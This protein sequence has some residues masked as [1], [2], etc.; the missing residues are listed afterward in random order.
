M[1]L[2]NF[3]NKAKN[4]INKTTFNQKNTVSFLAYNLLKKFVVSGQA[5]ASCLD[6]AHPKNT[7]LKVLKNVSQRSMKTFYKLSDKYQKNQKGVLAQSNLI[8]SDKR[9]SLSPK[10]KKLLKLIENNKPRYER[11]DILLDKLKSR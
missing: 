3:Y 6:N 7:R 11:I 2:L 8:Q 10:A 4:K 9:S 1:G 5:E